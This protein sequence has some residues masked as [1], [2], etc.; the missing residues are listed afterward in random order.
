MD[1]GNGRVRFSSS[2]IG[3]SWQHFRCRL[4]HSLHDLKQPGLVPWG[5]ITRGRMYR[6]IWCYV[7]SKKTE[8]Y[9]TVHWIILTRRER[10]IHAAERCT[11]HQ[12]Y[13][14]DVH[15]LQI[16]DQGGHQ[17]ASPLSHHRNC[18]GTPLLGP[19]FLPPRHHLLL[20]PEVS[21]SM[22]ST[23]TR[24]SPLPQM[25]ASCGIL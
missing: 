2:S 6:D 3:P 4:I 8:Q 1:L 24:S 7:Q 15:V 10:R 25:W 17:G 14:L 19:C 9:Q 12:M 16:L 13:R 23:R 21:A 22:G 20:Q 5:L 11:G 18:Q